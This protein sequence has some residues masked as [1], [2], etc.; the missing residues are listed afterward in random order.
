MKRLMVTACIAF[1]SA[2]PA[3]AAL[4]VGATAPDFSA[5][6]S[7]AGKQFPDGLRR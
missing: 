6:A 5:Q 4:K 3:L 2:G 1:L 7:Q